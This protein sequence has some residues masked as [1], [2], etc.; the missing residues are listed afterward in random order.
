[1]SFPMTASKRSITRKEETS[2]T[3]VGLVIVVALIAAAYFALEYSFKKQ[4][5]IDSARTREFRQ[6]VQV[7][8][9]PD[10]NADGTFENSDHNRAIVHVVT[11][12]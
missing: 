5:R 12:K 4:D 2:L 1:M 7:Q 11:K 3:P 10:L 8:Q 9:G 6:M